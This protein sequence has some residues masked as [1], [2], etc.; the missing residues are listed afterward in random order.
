MRTCRLSPA[1]S[2]GISGIVKITAMSRRAGAVA[3]ILTIADTTEKHQVL[4]I[5][6]VKVIMAEVVM[7]SARVMDS[8][9]VLICRRAVEPQ[10]VPRSSMVATTTA[11]PPTTT[12]PT[13]SASS[14]LCLSLPGD[15]FF[16]HSRAA[17]RESR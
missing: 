4:M 13:S 15:F 12:S 14:R 2:T 9:I 3:D 7:N 10:A 8:L 16:C 17:T 6:I 1:R 5:L 11:T